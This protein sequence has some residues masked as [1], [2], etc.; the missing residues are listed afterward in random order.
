[1]R[2]KFIIGKAGTAKTTTLVRI[3]QTS[4]LKSVALAFTHSACQNMVEKGM[5]NVHTLH[6]YFRILPNSNFININKEL[7]NIILIDEF[8]MIPLKLIISILKNIEIYDLKKYKDTTVVLCGDFLQLPPI[9]DNDDINIQNLTFKE[10]INLNINDSIKIIN[11]IAKTIYNSEYYQKADKLILNK[12]YRCEDN[13]ILTLNEIMNSKQIKTIS[14]DEFK[15]L[16]HDSFVFL[17]STYENLKKMRDLTK[18]KTDIG[19]E[20]RI[21]L[22]NENKSL[23]TTNI[24]DKWH[25]GDFVEV[26]EIAKDYVEIQ[27]HNHKIKLTKNT[28]NIYDLLPLNFITVHYAQGRGFNNV[29][30][31]IDDLFEIGMLYTAITRAKK[32]I[33]FITFKNQIEIEDIIRRFNI[34]ETIIYPELKNNNENNEINDSH[35]ETNP[36]NLTSILK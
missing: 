28:H 30:L 13:V 8:S 2:I 9:A 6:S 3:Q 23:L 22:V 24:N 19:F 32:Q 21:G 11:T 25:N 14:V 31:C 35:V 16:N 7:P 27:K 33:L 15:N 34:L 4:K 18:F 5:L 26:V 1:M 36:E 12:N 17:A 10:D 29:V 20:T